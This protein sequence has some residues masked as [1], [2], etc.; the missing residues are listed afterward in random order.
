MSF[1]D[2]KRV[3]HNDARVKS[4]HKRLHVSEE[5]GCI[6]LVAHEDIARIRKL[7]GSSLNHR[8]VR[9]SSQAIENKSTATVYLR[10]K[11]SNKES[12]VWAVLSWITRQDERIFRLD[13]TANAYQESRWTVKANKMSTACS[14]CGTMTI[15]LTILIKVSSPTALLIWGN[16]KICQSAPRYEI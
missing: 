2:Q 1:A 5:A 16:P 9:E 15:L 10:N 6:W 14:S 11:D 12:M 13:D 7:K 4:L 8:V 3:V